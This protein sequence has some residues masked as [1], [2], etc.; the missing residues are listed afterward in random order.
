MLF[1]E[2]IAL[3][4]TPII[5]AGITQLVKTLPIIA[6][7]SLRVP[8]IRA[9]VAVLSLITA[10]MLLILGDITHEEFDPGLVETAV[11]AVFNALSATG[12]WYFTKKMR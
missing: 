8:I 9:I 7:A 6:A 10:I 2:T 1:I 11:L 5:V 3:V 4:L 12:I